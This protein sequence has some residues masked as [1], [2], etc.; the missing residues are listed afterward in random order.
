[1]SKVPAQWN[2]IGRVRELRDL[3]APATLMVGNGDVESREQA[4]ALAE[5]Y[6]L[7]GVM[8][9]RGVFHDP[10]AFSDESPWES[11]DTTQKL[12]LYT[13]HV[14]LF[15]KTWQNGERPIHTLN[16]FCKI[17]INGF[18]GAKELR[19]QLMTAR[20]TSELLDMLEKNKLAATV[21]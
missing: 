10:F 17:Y 4:L 12:D 1:M 14:K 2:E 5:K 21:G 11:Y 16:K 6:R 20:S 15:A 3:L 13:K 9:G 8:I 7:D 18:D 19:E